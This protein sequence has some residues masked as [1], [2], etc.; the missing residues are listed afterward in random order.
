MEAHFWHQAWREKR[1]GFHKSDVNP[2]LIAHEE[3]LFTNSENIT[4]LPMCGKSLDILWCSHR[5][6]QVYGVELS[7][8]AI[9]EFF[10]ENQL[11]YKQTVK[12]KY[13]IFISGNITIYCGDFFTLP[14]N[15][16]GITAIF[17]RGGL[18][19]LP[20]D[21][22]EKY[23]RKMGKEL[24]SEVTWLLCAFN[25]TSDLLKGPPFSISPLELKEAL[26]SKFSVTLLEE[27]ANDEFD[28]DGIR[29]NIYLIS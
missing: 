22:R 20:Q 29:E 25:Y 28:I 13:K 19:A 2:A 6:K 1:I 7:E 21:M 24:S 14:L 10:K 27:V 16:L 23:Y 17:D 18:G 8:Q 15:E 12:D 4:F 26:S 3:K 11:N 5:S 9:I